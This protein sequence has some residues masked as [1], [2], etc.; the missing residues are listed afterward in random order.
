MT[1][2]FVFGCA[3]LAL[4]ALFH[5]TVRR[6]RFTYPATLVFV[7]AGLALVASTARCDCGTPSGHAFL[8]PPSLAILGRIHNTAFYFVALPVTLGAGLVWARLR[9]DPRFRQA[10]RHSALQALIM[11]PLT[12]TIFSGPTLHFSTFYLWL[13]AWF[14]WQ[15]HIAIRIRQVR[16]GGL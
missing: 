4:A 15:T 3:T 14:A 8:N 10:A 11:I 1:N 5:A 2:F 6:N 7:L 13:L 9:K 16:R 12:V